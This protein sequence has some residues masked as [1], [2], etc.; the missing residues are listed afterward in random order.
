MVGRKTRTMAGTAL[1]ALS[2]ILISAGCGN[3]DATEDDQ[4]EAARH[5]AGPA[6]A[7]TEL[8]HAGGEEVAGDT[9]EAPAAPGASATS[10]T[11]NEDLSLVV[12]GELFFPYGFY[13]IMK[14]EMKEVAEAGFNTALTMRVR[15][16]PPNPRRATSPGGSHTSRDVTGRPH[17]FSNGIP[18]HAAV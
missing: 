7:A 11:I 5:Q 14:D 10:V 8:G 18:R 16:K 2:L 12:D 15:S 4:P 9:A 3:G 1:V 17:K 6:Q 13:G